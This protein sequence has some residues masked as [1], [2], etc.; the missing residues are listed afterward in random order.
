VEEHYGIEGRNQVYERKT[1]EYKR[2]L[3][4]AKHN[5]DNDKETTENRKKQINNLCVSV[6]NMDIFAE[7]FW[8]WLQE[9]SYLGEIIANR[10]D[11]VFRNQECIEDSIKINQDEV[12]ELAKMKFRHLADNLEEGFQ[13]S[14]AFLNCNLTELLLENVKVFDYAELGITV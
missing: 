14:K 12:I 8:S 11:Y 10:L 5:W 7:Q 6:L 9:P 4:V 1:I 13:Y 2:Y 3:D